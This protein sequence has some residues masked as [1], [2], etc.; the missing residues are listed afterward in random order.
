MVTVY[1]PHIQAQID[2]I[3]RQIEIL[4]QQ[5]VY[6]IQNSVGSVLIH[7]DELRGESIDELMARLKH[8]L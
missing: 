6:L 5:K 2:E 4:I 8:P 7:K 3:D 1:P